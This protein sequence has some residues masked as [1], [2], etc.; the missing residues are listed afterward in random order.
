MAT[1]AQKAACKRY[2]EKTK[3]SH[4]VIMLRFNRV[5]DRDVIAVLESVP[6]KTQ[7]IRELVRGDG[8]A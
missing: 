2:Y 1:E 8:D 7:Y 3:R 5:A 4:K 6:N